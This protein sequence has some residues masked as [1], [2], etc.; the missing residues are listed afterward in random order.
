MGYE[1]LTP[2]PDGEVVEYTRAF[3]VRCPDRPVIPFIEG[4]GIGPDIWAASRRVFDADGC[5]LR[6]REA[7]QALFQ[8]LFRRAYAQ[9]AAH[10]VVRRCHARRRAAG[11]SGLARLYPSS[12]WIFVEAVRHDLERNA[13][14]RHARSGG[15]GFLL[16]SEIVCGV[17]A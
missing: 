9:H 1:R 6:A 12:T 17:P 16:G 5:F 15:A 11:L 14:H 8:P 2:P 10:H 7:P 13:R 4:D 3:E